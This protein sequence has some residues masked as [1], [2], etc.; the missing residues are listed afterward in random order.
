MATRRPTPPKGTPAPRHPA[1]AERPPRRTQQASVTEN[2]VTRAF[3]GLI[4][5]AGVLLL[6][7]FFFGG[8]WGPV[9]VGV[10]VFISAFPP[11]RRPVDRWLTGQAKG[12][13]ADQAAIIR[14]GGGLAIVLLALLLS[15]G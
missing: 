13:E 10:L 15:P 5:V 8:R 14:M 4:L 6:T 9:M 11:A 1:P 2:M 12:E 3:Q 7:T